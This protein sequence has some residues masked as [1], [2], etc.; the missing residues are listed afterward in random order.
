MLAEAGCRAEN[1]FLGHI[2][3]GRRDL[4]RRARS[5]ARTP[6]HRQP[7]DGRA[8]GNGFGAPPYRGVVQV[9]ARCERHPLLRAEDAA[10][11][12]PDHLARRRDPSGRRSTSSQKPHQPR[13]ARAVPPK[14]L[15]GVQVTRLLCL[16]RLRQAYGAVADV[17]TDR[18]ARIVPAGSDGSISSPSEVAS[19]GG[20]PGAGGHAGRRDGGVIGILAAD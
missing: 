20:W 5:S 16:G 4:G 17:R 19:S 10:L 14:K 1:L 6:R 7:L 3:A 13:S 8:A 11:E 9:L 15:G 12:V 18:Y 2:A